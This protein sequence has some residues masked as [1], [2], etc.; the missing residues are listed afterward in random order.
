MH[1]LSQTFLNEGLEADDLR[2]LVDPRVTIDEYRS[3]IGSDS[4]VMVLTFKVQGSDPA[5]DL[6]SFMEKGY[7][8]V[9]DADASSGELDDGSYLVFVETD[10]EQELLDKLILMFQDLENLTAIKPEEWTIVNHKPYAE[11]HLTKEDMS[12]II[13]WSPEAYEAAHRNLKNSIDS[14]KTAAGVKV[15]TR[16]PKNDFTE[17]LRIAAGI[18]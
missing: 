13:S 16:A 2:R 6:V 10:R 3:K 4:A 1:Q 9:L 14:L 18:R 11:G 8:W 5:L 17:S 7:D 15:E 12:K